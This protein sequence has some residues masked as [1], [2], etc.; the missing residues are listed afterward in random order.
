[1]GTFATSTY[2]GRS[3]PL[4]MLDDGDWQTVY[5]EMHNEDTGNEGE[6]AAVVSTILVVFV[7]TPI[8]YLFGMW[9]YWKSYI[10]P[11]HEVFLPKYAVVPD[12]LKGSFKYDLCS[13]NDDRDSCR[14]C[15]CFAFCPS[16][17]IS[18]Y[19]YRAGHLPSMLGTD[20][21]CNCPGW[22]WVAG[23][24]AYAFL[25]E[26]FGCCLLCAFAATRNGVDFITGRD[27]NLTQDGGLDGVVPHRVRFGIKTEGCNTF[28]I[29]CCTWC[30][31]MSCA[32]TQEY[33]QIMDIFKAGPVQTAPPAMAGGP[34]V[35]GQPIQV[36]PTLVT[37]QVIDT[38]VVGTAKQ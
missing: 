27:P 14:T 7:V 26:S 5:D 15:L 8:I 3:E 9:L 12:H 37:G 1:M 23:V 16:C 34:A 2:E 6:Q 13:F 32:G 28:C 33:R 38:N 24:L 25:S 35:V 36:A 10:K 30:W 29:D 18:D 19:W 17:M 21:V 11:T 20:I 22:Q 31:C 4:R